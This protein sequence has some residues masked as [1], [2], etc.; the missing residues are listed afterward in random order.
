M[1]TKLILLDGLTKPFSYM[2]FWN[3]VKEIYIKQKQL[4]LLNYKKML[5]G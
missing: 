1:L 2:K 5:N 3:F 4:K